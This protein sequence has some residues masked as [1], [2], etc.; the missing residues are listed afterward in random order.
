[1]RFEVVADGMEGPGLMLT[2]PL[3]GN[4][5]AVRVILRPKSVHYF[6]ERDGE[7]LEVDHRDEYVDRG[8]YLLL[9]EL[10]AQA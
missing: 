4:G 6:L 9:A 5:D 1:M 7:V 3:A 8:I 10:S 2:L